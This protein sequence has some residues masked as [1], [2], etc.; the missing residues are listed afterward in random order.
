MIREAVERVLGDA[1]CR[2]AAGLMA[3]RLSGVDG[4]VNAADALEEVLMR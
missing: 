2:E 4:G 1:G 3:S